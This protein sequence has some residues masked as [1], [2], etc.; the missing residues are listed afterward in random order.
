VYKPARMPLPENSSGAAMTKAGG[1]AAGPKENYTTQKKEL[2]AVQTN[3]S[4][5][6][7]CCGDEHPV[8][9]CKPSARN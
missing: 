4:G 9:R 5:N 1:S 6:V 2:C 3:T 8:T 7:G